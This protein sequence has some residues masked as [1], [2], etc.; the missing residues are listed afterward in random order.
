MGIKD[1]K[2][3]FNLPIQTV[4][5]VPSTK[6]KSVKISRAEFEMRIE[7]VRN[8]LARMFGG[9]TEAR[10]FGGFLL[11]GKEIREDVA[12][13]TAYAER[14]TFLDKKAEWI[15][16]VK[17]W[18]KEWGQQSMGIIIENDLKYV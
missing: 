3:S 18:G 4:T 8:K 17:K 11:D 15:K 6:K 12:Q 5:F 10:V 7:E 2:G 13:V 16:N 9:Y 14:N 1:V